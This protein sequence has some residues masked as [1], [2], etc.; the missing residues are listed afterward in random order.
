MAVV[1]PGTDRWDFEVALGS[2]LDQGS[3]QGPTCLETLVTLAEDGQL[4]LTAVGRLRI[5]E[6]D[7]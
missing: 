1:C 5:D 3:I 4:A 7:I 2:L 6:D